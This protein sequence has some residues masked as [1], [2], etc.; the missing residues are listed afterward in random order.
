[1][2]HLKR[3][4]AHMK[5]QIIRTGLLLGSLALRMRKVPMKSLLPST[6]WIALA[7]VVSGCHPNAFTL[8]YV[9]PAGFRG[10]F[11]VTRDNSGRE[12]I[13]RSNNLVSVFISATGAAYTQS[14]LPRRK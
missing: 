5:R 2:S 1:R 14:E 8:E 6:F 3:I 12:D 9:V 10:M 7:L 4:Q 11:V 13:V